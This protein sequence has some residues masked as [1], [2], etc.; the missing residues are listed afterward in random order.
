M[1]TYDSLLASIRFEFDRNADFRAHVA[2][3]TSRLRGRGV[4]LPSSDR[5]CLEARLDDGRLLGK[6]LLDEYLA[7]TTVPQWMLARQCAGAAR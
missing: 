2:R 5:E 7:R 6:A 4:T 1:I 3:M